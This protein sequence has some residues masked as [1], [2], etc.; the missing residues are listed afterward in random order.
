MQVGTNCVTP[1]LVAGAATVAI[2]AAPTARGDHGAGQGGSY[3]GAY[4]GS[5][6]AYDGAGLGG[7]HAGGGKIGSGQ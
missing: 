4:C 6:T 5:Y 2:T 7:C 3:C 1:L